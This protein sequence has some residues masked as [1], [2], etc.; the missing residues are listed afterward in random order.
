MWSRLAA[1]VAAMPRLARY[2]L[3]GNIGFDI[4]A[5]VTLLLAGH[6]GLDPRLSRVPGFL[7]ASLATY[8]LNRH[9]TFGSA[10]RGGFWRGWAAYMLASGI[11]ALLNYVT[12]LSVVTVYGDGTWTVLAALFAGSLAGLS[13]GYLASSRLVFSHARR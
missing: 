4:D 10:A 1:R 7:L 3:V 8:L 6:T 13:V 5:A 11:G 2:L 9:W 12:Y